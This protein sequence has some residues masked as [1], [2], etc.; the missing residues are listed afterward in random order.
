MTNKLKFL[1]CSALMVFPI[2]GI[3][4]AET[5]QVRDGESIQEAVN[6]SQP[7]DT[8][9]VYPGTYKE[10]VFIDKDDIHL[11]GIIE[12]GE[13]PVLDGEG[14]LNDG[15]LLAGHGGTIERLHIK[16]YKGNGIMTQ[17]GNN[18]KV[19]HNR[20]IDTGVYGIFPQFG[21]NGLVAYNEVAII[22]DAA[23]YV[24]MCDNVDVLF[25]ETYDSVMGIET[26]NS[27][28]MLV[29][30]NV[31]RNNTVGMVISLVPG[32]PIKTAE[33]TIVRNNFITDNNLANFAPAGSIA[34][35]MPAGVGILILSADQSMVEKNIIR[36]NK[37]AG[38][39]VSDLASVSGSVVDPDLDPRPDLSQILGNLFIENGKDPSQF[40]K[41]LIE[42]TKSPRG[43]DLMSTGKGR[44]NCLANSEELIAIGTE[45]WSACEEGATTQ[46]IKT[47]QL[48][49]P[50]VA[51]PLTQEQIG[52]LTYLSVCS[53]CHSYTQTL[54]GPSMKTVKRMYRGRAQDM[55]DWIANPTQVREGYPPMPAQGYLPEDVRLEVARYILEDLENG[56]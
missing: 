34:H 12:A 31:M 54:I 37:S 19:I 46:D 5:L 41:P 52:R 38:I 14:K 47:T 25:N 53:G 35:G 6:K 32:L 24:G 4:V 13:W 43:P 48:D 44:K 23:I 51:P 15:V 33:R 36:N 3:A 26:E 29:E 27:R 20:V 16:H 30:G 42:F 56:E 7:G 10:T 17:G 2:H 1:L 9:E 40:F 28:D 18:F 11:K 21:K 39:L 55:A 50:V 8:I 45:K 49:S 22:E